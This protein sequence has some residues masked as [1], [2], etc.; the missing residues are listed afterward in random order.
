MKQSINQSIVCP[1]SVTRVM[2]AALLNSYGRP[3]LSLYPRHSPPSPPGQSNGVYMHAHRMSLLRSLNVAG[4]HWASLSCRVGR[5]SSCA[6]SRGGDID[7]G[8]R[9]RRRFS[10]GGT[11]G[12]GAGGGKISITVHPSGHDSSGEH[13]RRNTP[14]TESIT[15]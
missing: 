3:T 8:D 15:K 1:W 14:P 13:S 5:S 6:F 4:G 10:D 12:G 9:R 7:A 11:A 2:G